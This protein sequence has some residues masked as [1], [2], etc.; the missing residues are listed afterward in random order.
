MA[1]G[2]LALVCWAPRVEAQENQTTKT[3]AAPPNAGAD[4]VRLKD[5]GIFRGTISEYVPGV[6]VV[7]VTV[8]GTVREFPMADVAYA[9]PIDPDA[10]AAKAPADEE[11]QPDDTEL[12]ATDSASIG[13]LRL[14]SEPA[15]LTF[16]RQVSTGIGTGYQRLCTAPCKVN[17]PAGTAV[18]SLG[19][20][21]DPNSKG[22][23]SVVIPAGSSRLVGTFKSRA[24]VRAA[25]WV[26][27]VGS[28]VAGTAM[29]V[30]SYGDEQRCSYGGYCYEISDTDYVL[31]A[32]GTAV[33][34]VG[35]IAG[36]W[37]ALTPNVTKA[38][39]V[40]ETPLPEKRIWAAPGLTFNRLF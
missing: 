27:A 26:L 15:G 31:L 30:L 11:P 37:I 22:V 39:I 32:A 23:I 14:E 18:L 13:E 17:L 34:T 38:Q 33:A 8:A 28:L 9:G 25:G 5:G 10:A 24:G 36:I 35:L 16:Y 2:A 21:N 40:P 3:A 29:V 12:E 6:R 20:P 19:E 4:V 1:M 7:I